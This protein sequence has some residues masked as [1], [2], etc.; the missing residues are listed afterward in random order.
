[1]VNAHGFYHVCKTSSRCFCIQQTESVQKTW[2]Y[3][4]QLFL[5]VAAVAC[6]EGNCSFPH[7]YPSAEQLFLPVSSTS[8]S[9]NSDS[10]R[11]MKFQSV[12]ENA[13]LEISVGIEQKNHLFEC[14]FC[15]FLTK[16]AIR[17][18]YTGNIKCIQA[19][20]NSRKGVN[21]RRE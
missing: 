12:L 20:D 10:T 3:S 4:T 21:K 14:F 1:M 2:I 13:A 15:A 5:K 6:E 19:S 8:D 7:I 11:T 9:S 18:H 17:S 16:P